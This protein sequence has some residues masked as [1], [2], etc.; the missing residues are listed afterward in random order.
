MPRWPSGATRFGMRLRNTWKEGCVNRAVQDVKRAPGTQRTSDPPAAR[1]CVVGASGYAGAL[2]A[3][4]LWRHPQIALEAITARSE[5]GRRLDD[6]Y[7]RHRV[8]LVLEPFNSARLG[9]L[10]VALVS[11]PHGAAAEVVGAL[12]ASGLRVVDLS[13]DFRLHDLAAYESWYGDHGAPD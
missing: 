12:R 13:A 10:H 8:P 6:L 2:A 11:Y 9:G 3:A 4:I 5:V 7:P 1:A